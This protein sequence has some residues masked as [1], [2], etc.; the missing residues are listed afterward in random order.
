MNG[1]NPQSARPVREGEAGKA[2]QPTQR[3]TVDGSAFLERHLAR[4]CDKILEYVRL[5][6]P[7]KK[8]EALLLGGGYGR[9]EGGVLR[10][11][12]G[13]ELYNDLEFYV[14]LRGRDWLNESIF[15]DAL[16][17][18]GSGLTPAFGLDVEFK[19]LSLA[20][21]RRS[22]VNMFY[23]DLVM[24]HRWLVGEESLLAGCEHHREAANI[25][26]SE[27]TRLLMNRCTGL[28]FAREKLQQRYLTDRDADFVG[29]NLAKAQMAYGDAVLVALGQYHWS[30]RERHERLMN[31]AAAD[32]MPWLAEVQ[33]HHHRG[34]EFKLRPK[35]TRPEAML[36]L[37]RQH[38][39]LSRLGLR[40]WLWVEGRR[41]NRA[42]NSVTEYAFNPLNK[43][44]ETNPWRNQLV[45]LRT[46]GPAAGLGA[47]HY[48]RERL[49]HALTLL[50]WEFSTSMPAAMLKRIQ[51]ELRTNATEF[52]ALVRAYESLWLKYR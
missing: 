37:Q 17:K 26:L 1:A 40:L 20:R 9:G 34:V 48:P 36:E 32:D 24:G 10:T 4:T 41:L 28:L 29:R 13:D 14:S 16:H 22:P 51:A 25:P 30:C 43:C 27:A 15:G 18:L 6:V 11:E 8:L 47:F 46:F 38:G 33:R 2:P 39:E 44:P 31:V 7:E 19:I 50:L 5:L 42:F 52:S 35:R 23:Y 21:L 3:F 12:A 45:N 49:F